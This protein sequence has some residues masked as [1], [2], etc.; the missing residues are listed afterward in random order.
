[1]LAAAPIPYAIVYITMIVVMQVERTKVCSSE[2]GRS[3]DRRIMASNDH[4]SKL[5]DAQE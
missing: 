2:L 4:H 3:P 1:V 5:E